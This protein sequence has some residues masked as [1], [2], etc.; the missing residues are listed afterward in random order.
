M[1]E[2]VSSSL[3]GFGGSSTLEFARFCVISLNVVWQLLIS[4]TLFC[5]KLSETN[6]IM[7]NMFN[8]TTVYTDNGDRE[9]R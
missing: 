5:Q 1:L 7:F 6:S 9:T 8:T 4:V 3:R 2:T